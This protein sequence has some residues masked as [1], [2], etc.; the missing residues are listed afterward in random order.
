MSR[1]RASVSIALSVLIVTSALPVASSS[2]HNA[3]KRCHAP[4]R[5]KYQNVG[6]LRAHGSV[7]CAKARRV[8]SRWDERC[9]Y[10]GDPECYPGPVKI[11]IKPGY[12][13]SMEYV[14]CCEGQGTA[15]KVRCTARGHRIIHFKGFS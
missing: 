1:R 9:F 7:S 2:A 3:P 6:K 11:R 8:A 10:R 13:C 14:P 4:R 12:K 15:A 5:V